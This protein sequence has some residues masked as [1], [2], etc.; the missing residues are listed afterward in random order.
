MFD[1]LLPTEKLIQAIVNGEDENVAQAIAAGADVNADRSGNTPLILAASHG[2]SMA[3]NALLDA[4]ANANQT[5]HHGITPAHEAAKRG[6]ADM[7]SRLAQS[8]MTMLSRNNKAGNTPAHMAA[9]AGHLGCLQVLAV[10]DAAID[11]PGKEGKTPLMLALDR[12][13]MPVTRFLLE[14]GA[15]L[16]AQDESGLSARA[17]LAAWPAAAGLA[18]STSSG[19]AHVGDSNDGA[20]DEGGIDVGDAPVAEAAAPTEEFMGI[21]TIRK[22]RP[23]A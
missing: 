23:S 10:A 19:V 4:G 12:Q 18:T 13:D 14:K 3:F 9:S 7:L 8:P 21:G 6:H 1:K 15:R 17:R 11:E 5:N 22:R 16:D 20:S 2:N